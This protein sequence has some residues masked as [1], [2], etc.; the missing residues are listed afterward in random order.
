MRLLR[1]RC[2][3]AADLQQLRFGVAYE[4]HEDFALPA[5]LA[6]KAAHDFAEV[7]LERSGLGRQGSGACGTLLR[8]VVDELE[9]FFCAL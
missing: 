5:A 6:A 4:L 8:E 9:D 2:D 7:V 1:K 3:G